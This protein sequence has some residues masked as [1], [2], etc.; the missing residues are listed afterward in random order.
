MKERDGERVQNINTITGDLIDF[1]TSGVALLLPASKPKDHKVIIFIDE[2][3]I[4]STVVYSIPKED[5][6]RIG[7]HFQKVSN[8]ML[9]NI[10]EFVDKFSKG[11]PLKCRV[12][13]AL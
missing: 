11:I 2:L 8:E 3:K 13:D 12:E 1:S 10:G 9:I 7:F 6:F 5:C 4:D